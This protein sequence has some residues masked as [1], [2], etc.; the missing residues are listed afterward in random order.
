MAAV[1]LRAIKLIKTWLN[2]RTLCLR[3]GLSESNGTGDADVDGKG[4]G[5][6]A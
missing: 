6:G 2:A 4:R 3:R 5:D 1:P